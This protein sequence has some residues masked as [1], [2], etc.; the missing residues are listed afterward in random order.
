MGSTITTGSASPPIAAV[1][2][3]LLAGLSGYR[4]PSWL[5][6]AA[7]LMEGATVGELPRNLLERSPAGFRRRLRLFVTRLVASKP[8]AL[9]DV[10]V[11]DRPWPPDLAF[12]DVSWTLQTRRDLD[13]SGLRRE[14]AALSQLTYG[15]LISLPRIGPRAAF[16]FALTLERV[17]DG[18]YADVHRT[19]A[20][21][22][23]ARGAAVSRW[24][25]LV[26]HEDPRFRDLLPHS[27]ETLAEQLRALRH[28][29]ER[30]R[31]HPLDVALPAILERVAELDRQPL[32][33]S[34]RAYVQA[35]AGVV[36]EPLEAILARLGFDGLPPRSRPEAVR[37]LGLT[38][39]RLR[40]LQRRV[41]ARVPSHQVYMPALERALELLAQ[42]APCGVEAGA[43]LLQT[44]KVA[45]VPFHPASVLAAAE[46]CRHAPT[47]EIERRAE[48]LRIVTTSM[49]A[50][51][52]GIVSAARKRSRLYG[53]AK[54]Q[55][56]DAAG[57]EEMEAS[58]ELVRS[59]LVHYSHAA[60]LDADWFWLP[61]EP[62]NRLSTVSRAILAVN[63][64]LDVATLRTG[65]CRTY[66][67]RQVSSV[68]SEKALQLFY[69]SHPSFVVEGRGD[70]RPLVR[71]ASETELRK[72]DQLLVDILRSSATGVL[73]TASFRAACAAHGMPEKTFRFR[74]TYSA[75]LDQPTRGSWCLR[76]SL[77][78]PD[79]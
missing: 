26:S 36:A 66:R 68:P 16:E 3:T 40:Q 49:G 4:L 17:V 62:R 70:V 33:I 15:E 54:L 31:S 48:G 6:D 79:R 21:A 75:I 63:S 74:T 42:T 2:R 19:E 24:A 67:R 53:I 10:P 47:F 41:A 14:P 28:D 35:L 43:T 23:R 38:P 73:D 29:D 61:A 45:T 20:D 8:S 56:L 9:R 30:P 12:D 5:R 64:P 69:R 37:D 55:E 58:E 71:A 72:T 77:A 65:I 22:E 39:E 52:P 78:E 51:A 13:Q 59:V 11:L 57:P 25:H 60:F 18:A 7:G 50:A 76:G 27:R 1:P 34:L 44:E 32:E 46:L